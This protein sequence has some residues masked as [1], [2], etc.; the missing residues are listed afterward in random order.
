MSLHSSRSVYIGKQVGLPA[1]PADG[2]TDTGQTLEIVHCTCWVACRYRE[3]IV[4]VREVSSA[5][6]RV[7]QDMSVL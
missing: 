7:K 5:S 1:C 2:F 4:I 6:S 3:G